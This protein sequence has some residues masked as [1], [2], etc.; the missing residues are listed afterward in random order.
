MY[1]TFPNTQSIVTSKYLPGT[2]IVLSVDD[3]RNGSCLRFDNHF[4]CFE[5]FNKIINK[6]TYI[7]KS[8]PNFYAE[9]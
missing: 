8:T 5:I 9:A 7:N 3:K 4:D 6:R 1:S 2:P